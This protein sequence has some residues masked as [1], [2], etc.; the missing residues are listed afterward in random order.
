[1]LYLNKV[2]IEDYIVD[3]YQELLGKN[4]LADIQFL[5]KVKKI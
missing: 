2:V 3:N 4:F 1:M 5:V